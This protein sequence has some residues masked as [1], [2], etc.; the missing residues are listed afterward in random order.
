MPHS[1]RHVAQYIH[2][3]TLT[4]SLAPSISPQLL[5]DCE[6]S[7]RVVAHDPV[8]RVIEGKPGGGSFYDSEKRQ[9]TLDP[10]HC[11]NEDRALWITCHEGMHAWQALPYSE[12]P[13]STATKE[14]LFAQVGFSSCNNVIEDCAGND[15]MVRGFV[16]LEQPTLAVY[17]E[18]LA[19]RGGI[20][21]HADITAAYQRLGREPKFAKALKEVLH[22]W[23]EYRVTLENFCTALT[24]NGG[25]RFAD[26]GDQDVNKILKEADL[27][28]R[29]AINT[30]IKNGKEPKAE[31]EEISLARFRL[32]KDYVFPFIERLVKLDQLAQEQNEAAKKA[33]KKGALSSETMREILDQLGQNSPGEAQRGDSLPDP[34][35]GQGTDSLEGSPID[36][37]NLSDSAKQE[38]AAYQNALSEDEKGTLKGAAAKKLQDI[39]DAIAE[40]LKPKT[41]AN[42]CAPTHRQ[43]AEEAA[44]QEA[45]G[46]ETVRNAAIAQGIRDSVRRSATPYQRIFMDI[47]SRLDEVE[48]A[49]RPMFIPE[50]A[51]EWRGAFASGQRLNLRSA[52]RF[53]ADPAQYARLFDRRDEPTT[54]SYEF[55]LVIDRSDSMDQDNKMPETR[56]AAVFLIEL[57]SRFQ[58]PCCVRVYDHEMQVVKTWEDAAND[59]AVQT[60]IAEH[61]TPRGGTNDA[62]ALG[63]AYIE[64]AQRRE[65]HKYIIVLSD[66]DS[67]VETELKKIVEKIQAEGKVR[68]FHF[69]LGDNTEDKKGLYAGN[70]RGNLPITGTGSFFDVFT[71]VLTRM[72]LDPSKFRGKKV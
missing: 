48:A 27:A 32:V 35:M 31:V 59:L 26:A 63:K 47:A 64:S 41:T 69:G 15:G 51:E 65:R 11:E 9:V 39:D 2:M 21:N 46:Q 12:I 42:D 30:T 7:A 34:A 17:R 72:I 5:N 14:K 56:R 38:I 23:A 24:P 54:F 40:A 13:L 3:S 55:D 44:A 71:D 58:I 16:G 52:L 57:L 25:F 1:V 6:V 70:S 66:A 29:T 8:L 43:R 60:N 37:S 53:E 68:L 10:L 28:L 36:T 50:D 67:G 22:A 18:Q 19:Q 49:I 62:M 20:L 4:A 33:M 61:M 45:A